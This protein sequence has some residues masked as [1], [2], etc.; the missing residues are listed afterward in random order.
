MR[1][2]NVCGKEMAS[3]YIVA[4]GDEYYCSDECLHT[5]YTAEEYAELY[6]SDV[7]FWTEWEEA[8]EDT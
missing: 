7:A 5:V 8:D 6:E 2:C 3:G 4:D 1:R